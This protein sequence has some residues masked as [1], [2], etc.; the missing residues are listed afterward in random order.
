MPRALLKFCRR[1]GNLHIKKSHYFS[2]VHSHIGQVFLL[3]LNVKEA[4]IKTMMSV[5]YNRFFSNWVGIH[6]I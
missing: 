4:E 3:K 1:K 2:A 6:I 5:Q